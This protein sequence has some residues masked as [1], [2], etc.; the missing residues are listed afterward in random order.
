MN[1]PSPE[2]G[3][4]AKV[5]RRVSRQVLLLVE[6]KGHWAG[7]AGK[8]RVDSTRHVFDQSLVASLCHTAAVSQLLLPRGSVVD[9]L[10]LP[11]SMWA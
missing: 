3:I 9:A 11:L 2:F 5:L 6:H 4:Q 8:G 10:D 1:A 7:L